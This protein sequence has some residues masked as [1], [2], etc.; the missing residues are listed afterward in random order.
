MILQQQQQLNLGEDNSNR[1][2]S[3]GKFEAIFLNV[4]LVTACAY[5]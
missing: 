4:P 3:F 2:D 5:P 1:N